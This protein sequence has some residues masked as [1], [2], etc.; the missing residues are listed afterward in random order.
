MTG[1]ER[2]PRRSRGTFAWGVVKRRV[3]GVGVGLAGAG[4]VSRP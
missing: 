2:S 4:L 3:A 1:Q